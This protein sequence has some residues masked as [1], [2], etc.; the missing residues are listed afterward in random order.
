MKKPSTPF[1][2]TGYFGPD[3]FCDRENE[4][5]T[6]L[7]NIQ[8]KQSTTLTAIRRIGKTSLIKHLQNSISDEWIC[9]Y[10]DILPTENV[11]DFLNYLATSIIR[12][13]PEKS[14]VGSKIWTFIKSLRPVL[15]FDPLS[16]QPNVSFNIDINESKNQ[17][18]GL[19]NFLDNQ[20]KPVLISIDEFQRIIDYPEKNCDVFLRTIIQKLQNV[21][22]VFS[23]SQQHIMSDLFSNPSKPF[24]RST[25]FLSLDKIQFDKYQEF[26]IEKFSSNKKKIDEKVASEILNW[27]NLHTYYVQL[28]CNRVYI[29]SK[30]KVTSSIW[31]NE[32]IKLIKEQEYVFFTYRDM[33]TKPQWILLKAIA[34]EG[35]VTSITSKDFILKYGLGGSATVLRSVEALQ[36]KELIYQQYDESGKL[37]YS[38]YDVLFQRWLEGINI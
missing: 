22:F 18:E 28:L 36:T 27:T 23:G 11:N 9:I 8:G 34:T 35:N 6:L 24:Y 13:V 37:F 15:S 2:T 19:L 4:T 33:L 17:I 14:S 31:Q 3:Y 12:S 16:G 29:N 21:V 38:V 30:S 25:L 10:L 5:Q 32:A 26:I 7:S 1:P 20:K